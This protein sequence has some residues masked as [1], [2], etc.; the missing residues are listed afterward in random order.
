MIKINHIAMAFRSQRKV[1]RPPNSNIII[2]Y[3]VV[4]KSNYE[5][6]IK[7]DRYCTDDNTDYLLHPEE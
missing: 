3:Y 4:S 1:R 6:V 2:L 5:V 7:L